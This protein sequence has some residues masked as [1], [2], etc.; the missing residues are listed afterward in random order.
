METIKTVFETKQKPQ[1]LDYTFTYPQTTKRKFT[2][3][4]FAKVSR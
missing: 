4:D 1:R 3:Y 2:D